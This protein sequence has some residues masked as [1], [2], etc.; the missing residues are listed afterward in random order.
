[1]GI[2]LSLA[3]GFVKELNQIGKEKRASK[4]KAAAD[5]ADYLT[6][7]K[8]E[9]YKAQ[10]QRGTDAATARR[11]IEQSKRTNV[12]DALNQALEDGTIT[13]AGLAAI[14]KGFTTFDPSYVDLSQSKSAIDAAALEYD[15]KGDTG[16]FTWNLAGEMEYGSGGSPYK[17]AQ[18]LWDT[19][20]K[21]LGTEQGYKEALE[22][23][24]SDETARANLESL[25][26]KNEFELRV[27]NITR[28]KFEK[29]DITELD[30]IDLGA[31]YG[32]AARLFDE[33]GFKNV[34]ELSL[35]EI[36]GQIYDVAEDETALLFP[37]RDTSEGGQTGGLFIPVKNTDIAH[38]DAMAARTG[39]ES[40]QQMVAAFAYRSSE[41]RENET[42]VEFAT[43][44]NSILLKAAKLESQGYGDMLSNP[45]LIS[46][47]KAREF[48]SVLN[49][50]FG[51]DREAAIQA[52]S[53]LV[54]T[55]EGV[56]S[57]TRRYRYAGNVN[58]KTV[59]L[60]TG[61]AFVKDITGLDPDKFEEGFKAQEDAVEYID[62]LMQL[63]QEL[64]E[65]LG[66]GWVR[67]AAGVLKSFGIQ[68]AQGTR[69]VSQL[70]SDNTD[71]AATSGDTS[72]SDLQAVIKE[73][74]PTIDLAA[75]SE[76]DAIKLTLAAKMARAVDP[77]GRLS[78]QDFEIQLRRLGS[79]NFS[80]P[81]G[82]KAA[83]ELV[84]KDFSKDLEYKRMLK[85]VMDDK[86]KLTPQVA[87][88]V[89]AHIRM[90]GLE[91][92]IFGAKGR[93][94][95]VRPAEQPA[96]P[97]SGAAPEPSDP[98]QI[99]TTP[100]SKRLKGQP[101]TII[102]RGSDDKYYLDPEGTNPVPNPRDL[103]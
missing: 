16:V 11:E 32:N 77:S 20:E 98:A 65:D 35:K 13:P 42:D 56:F 58:Q 41:R 9:L 76:A 36:A 27:G 74:D 48:Y 71:F 5:A 50:T 21:Q 49:E 18:V 103:I 53:M 62:R 45:A 63:E 1:M 17:R 33:L 85:A 102:Y 100:S 59:A 78:N 83:L 89:Q 97:D 82:I 99:T 87:R 10:L 7:Q 61:T 95:L 24:Q 79:G 52:V 91:K 73:V 15:V 92:R 8:Q 31:Q 93:D 4:A 101:N 94:A 57:K 75:I 14:G 39:Y 30:F 66:T 86:T 60:Q 6:F 29:R 51:D 23:F 72:Q 3:S 28:Q 22:F 38:L 67:S 34:E 12:A 96:A 43:R 88:T 40:T 25:V 68:V 70:F 54:A 47:E 80:T 81:E 37:T 64:G 44:Q 55:P 2:G 84:R 19:W 90:R 46:E 26:K 69:T